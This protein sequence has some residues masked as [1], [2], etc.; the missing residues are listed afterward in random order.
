[1][2]KDT[3]YFSHDYNARQDEK[4]A[5]YLSKVGMSGY[6]I[7]W[8]LIERMHQSE[9]GKLT[10]KYLN[11]IA[12]ADNIDITLLNTCYN[13]AIECELFVTDDKYFWSER[14][15]KNKLELDEKR[16]KKSNAGK[17]G[18]QKRWAKDNSVITNDN[19]TI[20]KPIVT[21]KQ[22]GRAHV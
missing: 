5:H 9:S 7:Y 2:K 12:Y 22:I 17:A 6:G 20:T 3:Y 16:V 1:M 13:I 14:V 15:L 21:G 18:M 11:G 4:I 10:L 19:R 8:L